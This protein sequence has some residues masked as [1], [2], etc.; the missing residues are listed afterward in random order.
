M[1]GHTRGDVSRG[2]SHTNCRHSHRQPMPFECT[3]CISGHSWARPP[4]GGTRTWTQDATSERDWLP[5]LVKT[6]LISIYLRQ[7][8]SHHTTFHWP[9]NYSVLHRYNLGN[10]N[11][12]IFITFTT[13][14]VNQVWHTVYG[15]QV[16]QLTNKSTKPNNPEGSTTRSHNNSI[17]KPPR[18]YLQSTRI[19]LRPPRYFQLQLMFSGRG[20]TSS[21][22]GDPRL[23]HL[24]A[25]F[26]TFSWP[27]S[28][29]RTRRTQRY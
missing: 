28:L 24:F 29:I 22:N 6:R 1:H 13:L 19:I 8:V 11:R 20:S 14:F 10:R 27:E 7:A 23:H 12:S 4:R 5:F 16:C 9:P 26:Q 2:W 15:L 21:N 17:Y 3:R 18:I 25:P